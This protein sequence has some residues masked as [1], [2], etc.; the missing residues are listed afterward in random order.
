MMVESFSTFIVKNFS[1]SYCYSRA[2]YNQHQSV[3][4]SRKTHQSGRL[5]TAS[6]INSLCI[7]LT[8]TN[9][10]NKGINSFP[11]MLQLREE[12]QQQI[13]VSLNKGKY[14]CHAKK[15]GREGGLPESAGR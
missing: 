8:S 7:L 1:S 2:Y 11:L 5:K 9:L 14:F 10:S 13:Q 15:G 6:S 3:T 12:V 4:H